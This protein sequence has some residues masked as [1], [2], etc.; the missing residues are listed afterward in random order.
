MV[1]LSEERTS[2]VSLVGVS[3]VGCGLPGCFARKPCCFA[4]SPDIMLYTGISKVDHVGDMG[5]YTLD[6]SGHN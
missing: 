2:L 3:V 4:S 6:F 1:S 5:A